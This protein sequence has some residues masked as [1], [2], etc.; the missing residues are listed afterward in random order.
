MG[1]S[2]KSLSHGQGP[3]RNAHARDSPAP[4]SRSGGARAAA[5][6]PRPGPDARAVAARR[7][8][9]VQPQPRPVGLHGRRRR[10]RAAHDPGH[11]HGR[12]LGRDRA[13]GA[14]LA[15]CSARDSRRHVRRARCVA[16]PG[17]AA[18]R[19]RG[20]LHGRHLPRAGSSRACG[21]RSL[22]H[23]GAASQRSLGACGHD[24]ERGPLLRA[25]RLSRA[26]AC[27]HRPVPRR[28]DGGRR[29][30]RVGRR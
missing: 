1:L 2:L 14:D 15:W 28:G 30:V 27:R 21:S 16:G 23:G 5:G 6:R 7:A 3:E 4:N 25:R 19:E 10:R 12:S 9:H 18:D 8:A 22:A 29:A 24:H 11:R 26:F 20:D 17:R 13:L